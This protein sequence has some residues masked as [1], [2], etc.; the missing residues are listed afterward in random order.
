MRKRNYSYIMLGCLCIGLVGCTTKNNTTEVSPTQT[1]EKVEEVKEVK[2]T[3]MGNVTYVSTKNN[4]L[5]SSGKATVKTEGLCEVL[6]PKDVS[7]QAKYYNAFNRMIDKYTLDTPSL[8][9]I[10]ET[11]GVI[12]F[13]NRGE[14]EYLYRIKD[15][16]VK[17][18]VEM[19]VKEVYPYGDSVYFMIESYG[20]Y[21]LEGM[22]SGDIFCYTPANGEIQLVYPL[23][24]KE[25]KATSHQLLVN[26]NGIYFSYHILVAQT[27]AQQR[28]TEAYY[29]HL[30]FGETEP[31]EDTNFMTQAGN[32]TYM[33]DWRNSGL[34]LKNRTEGINDTIQLTNSRGTACIV[35]DMAYF[36][37]RET[38]CCMN[39]KTGEQQQYNFSEMI[40]EAFSP[41]TG[42]TNY[43]GN[44][45]MVNSF[46]VIED[47]IWACDFGD[48][49]CLDV[50]T[51]EMTW[52][53]L[54]EKKTERSYYGYSGITALY[55]DGTDLYCTSLNFDGLRRIV[56]EKA[57]LNYIEGVPVLHVV[58]EP[59][60]K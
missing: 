32:E 47:K 33:M 22:K 20:K 39:L 11:T 53:S 26:E 59:V 51:G 55:T 6:Q 42:V 18:A 35:D 43:P 14:D 40:K 46:L 7:K 19:P 37:T 60:D 24:M 56:I 3:N 49:Y 58:A 48:L 2:S 34:S 30:P 8:F 5:I 25:N 54:L 41:K 21:E 23:G 9:C 16:E 44:M 28:I 4:L 13:V 50:K 36:S 31:I 52:Y 27:L 15:G 29:Y 10:D 57:E 17:L 1:I 45:E 38:V 12:Y